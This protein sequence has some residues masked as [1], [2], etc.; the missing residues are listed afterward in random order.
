M[1][2][3]DAVIFDRD[4][5][6]FSVEHHMGPKGPKDWG[7]FNSG[8][9]DDCVVPA[10]AAL[11]RFVRDQSTAKVIITS[12]REDKTRDDMLTGMAVHDVLPDYLFMRASG[13]NRKDSIVKLEIY[14]QEIEPR[15]NVLFVVDDRQQVVDAWR[16]I[17]LNV[18]QV[19]D[20]GV[21]P[22]YGDCV[23][24][25]DTNADN[26]PCTECGTVHACNRCSGFRG[27]D[28]RA[29]NSPLCPMCSLIVKVKSA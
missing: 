16:S 10:V 26:A 3:Q 6:L 18:I 13:D 7:A 17:G 22:C 1:T 24:T 5:T 12:G 14:A 11:F 4:G 19:T 20:T 9:A 21:D 8:A 27:S 15:F 28:E 25:F 29:H 23:K 2:K